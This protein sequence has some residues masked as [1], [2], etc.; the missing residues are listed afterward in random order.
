MDDQVQFYADL[1]ERE[2]AAGADHGLWDLV[3]ITAISGRQRACYE[4][5]V[6]R[7]L[8]CKRLPRCFEYLVV[9][10][11]EGAKIGSGGST[12]NVLRVL[13]ERYGDRLYTLKVLL[14]HCGGYSQRVPFNTVLGKIFAPV[15]CRSAFVNDVLDIQLAIF[16]PLSLHMQPGKTSLPNHN[17]QKTKQNS[18]NSERERERENNT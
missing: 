1:V 7:K 4:A 14:L 16:T 5:Q 11:P 10:D 6:A 8:A 15:P 17:S 18:S 9:A 13:H 12:L 3:V 2:G